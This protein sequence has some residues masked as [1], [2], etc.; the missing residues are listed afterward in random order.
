MPYTPKNVTAN[1][2]SVKKKRTAK[3]TSAEIAAKIIK[4]WEGFMPEPYLCPGGVPTI[5]YGSTMYENGDRVAMDDCKIDRKRGEEILLYFIK[6]VEQQVKSVLEVK[7]N[8]NQLAA[9]VSLTYNIGIGNFS[10][11]TLL[12]WINSNPSYSGGKDTR[13]GGKAAAAKYV[14]KLKADVKC[15]A[16]L[17]SRAPLFTLFK[18]KAMSAT[19]FPRELATSIK[20]PSARKIFG[21]K[22][23]E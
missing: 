3:K 1:M 11:S 14:L 20:S 13:G 7:L 18:R 21:G 4:K 8:N 2:E 19:D 23:K 15:E 10:R 12:A 16:G 6:E 9:L 22:D 5:G 17:G